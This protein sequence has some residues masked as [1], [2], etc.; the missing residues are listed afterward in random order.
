MSY[1]TKNIRNIALLGHGNSGKTT[2]AESMLYTTGAIDRQGKVTDGNTV[3]DYDPE[4]VRRQ[5]TISM[6]M[7]PVIFKDTKI[8]V[9]DCPG[10]QDF[11]GEA[12]GAIAAAEAGLILCT[13]KDGLSVGA[14]RSWKLLEKANKPVMFYISKLNE[15]H[16]DYAG[17][18][19][20]IKGKY[21][22]IV[23]PVFAPLSSGNGV[24]DLVHN[25]AYITENG[26]TMV[27]SIP[28]EDAGTAEELRAEL[29]EAAAGATEELMDKF[30]ENMELDESDIVK[31][32]QAGVRDRSVVPVFCGSADS[33]IGT[34][35]LLSAI[36]DYVP[37]PHSEVGTETDPVVLYVFK[38]VSDQ[39]GK[40]S[41]VKVLSGKLAGDQQ[42]RNVRTG[43][44]DRLGRLYVMTGKKNAEVK[45]ASY[46]DIVAIG[47]MDWKTG[48]TICD[49][50]KEVELPVLDLPTP[51]YS[52]AITPK[53]RGQDDKI[54]AGLTKLNEED[55]SFRLEN[56]SETKQMVLSGAGD[57]QL[58]VLCS[59]LK[60]RF[61]V[62]AELSPARVPY[63][64]KIKAKVEAHGRHKKQTGGSGQFGDVWIRFEPQDE[65]DDM[66][67]AEEVFGGSVPKNFFPAV[68]KGL[69]E[70]VNKG[71]LAGYPLVGLKA[72]LYDGSYHPVDSNEMAF[73]TAAQLA[74]KDGIPRAKPTILE[75]IGSLKVTIPDAN[76][77]D[78]M[79]DI[80]SKRRGTVLGMTA[81]NGM[82]I[83]EAEVPMAEMSS[84]TID[85]RSMTQGRGSFTLEFSRYEEAP[86]NVQ[87]KV[88]EEAKR[89]S[90][91]ENK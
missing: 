64:E 81:E 65:S 20:Q 7:A 37:E 58:D 16:S 22:S 28:A 48:D 74:Y 17:T 46:G 73:K 4:E 85:L 86:Q 43:S 41:L 21:G 9:L 53:T 69:R 5:I 15:E 79:S 90:E 57:M 87:Q 83:V 18:L 39:F 91:E 2:L 68:E 78:I 19:A 84:Y 44:T 75:P 67:F 23:C 76:L 70:A 40:Y 62:E 89:L 54:A 30:F 77:G 47:K 27:G 29:M 35:A 34:E 82:Q 71:V 11:V 38:T 61:G 36:V 13:A 55:P 51:C 26:K 25:K 63:R 50:K 31:G 66:I 10:Y 3:C 56:N 42:L 60:S 24:I 12:I 59:K 80:S 88:I 32:L 14:E 33:G 52:M 45:E 8:N 6:S 1:N 72:T 49:A